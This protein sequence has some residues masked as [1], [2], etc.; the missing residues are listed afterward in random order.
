LS[1]KNPW[2]ALR[3]YQRVGRITIP[4]AAYSAEI[5][6]HYKLVQP[7]MT[8]VIGRDGMIKY[9]NTRALNYAQFQRE[10]DALP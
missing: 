8:Y 9:K 3:Q 6:R 7:D 4:L 10:L 2:G 1:P 5:V